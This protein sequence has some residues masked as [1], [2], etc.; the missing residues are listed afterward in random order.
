MAE[1]KT[2]KAA[3]DAKPK[4]AA[5]GGKKG[6][7]GKKDEPVEE[8]L[9]EEDAELKAN[10]ELMVTRVSDPE[11]PLQ[12]AALEGLRK[13]IRTA[14]SSMTSVPKPLKFLRPHYVKLKEVRS[15]DLVVCAAAPCSRWRAEGE[16]RGLGFGRGRRALRPGCGASGVRG[17]RFSWRGYGCV[18]CKAMRRRCRRGAAGRGS[19]GGS[20]R[21]S[22]LRC[23]LRDGSGGDEAPRLD[24]VVVR[25]A[26][27]ELSRFAGAAWWDPPEVD[28][29]QYDA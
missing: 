17:F 8:E 25:T 15:R 14:T 12:K 19:N 26:R 23:R 21:G 6:L 7:K 10:L 22:A 9:S 29:T 4:G 3:E 13:E 27:G 1:D 2:T 24:R 28:V 5:E 11:L 20:R 18:G 16:T